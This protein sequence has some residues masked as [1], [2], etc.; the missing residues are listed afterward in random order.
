MALKTVQDSSLTAV[1]NAIRVKGSISGTLEFPDGF[2]SAIQNLS[3]SGNDA[4]VITLT[5][6][7]AVSETHGY[8]WTPDCSYNDYYEA[9]IQQRPIGLKVNCT[10]CD[11]AFAMRIN[12]NPSRLEYKIAEV[13]TDANYNAIGIVI[14]FY[15]FTYSGVTLKNEFFTPF[16]LE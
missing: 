6:S 7:A 3:P 13:V 1:A 4:L 11:D 16:P 10:I 9:V 15:W 14:K 12:D 2:V 5:D 8:H